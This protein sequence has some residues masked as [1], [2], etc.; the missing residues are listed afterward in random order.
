MNTYCTYL[1]R[2]RDVQISY[3]RW[4]GELQ[5]RLTA[6]INWDANR[7][8][9]Q[10]LSVDLQLDNKGRWHRGGHLTFYYPGRIV[11]GEFEFLLKG[12][13]SHIR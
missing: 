3:Q 4:S 7:D 9:S 11:N 5:K 13:S 10:K 12:K 8:P 2:L 6:A 1:C